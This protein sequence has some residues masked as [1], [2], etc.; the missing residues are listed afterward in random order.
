MVGMGYKQNI[1]AFRTTMSVIRIGGYAVDGEHVQVPGALEDWLKVQAFAA[2]EVLGL[3]DRAGHD[4]RASAGEGCVIEVTQQDSFTAAEELVRSS[5]GYEGE[6]P[7]LVLNFANPV[8][9][10]GGVTRGARAQEEDL[11][12]R[13]TLYLSLN[14][15]AAEP[16]YRENSAAHPGLFTH[17]ALVS[18]HVWVLRS[19]DMA[20]MREPVEVAVITMAAPYVPYTVAVTSAELR[21]TVAT[22]IEGMLRIAE[23]LGYDRLVLGAWGC[24]VFGNDPEQVASCFREALSRC[25][26]AFQQVRFAVPG[27]S[28]NH[29]V[30][31][32]V[33][34]DTDGSR[35][36]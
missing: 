27:P 1:R 18:P 32:R 2:D 13:S 20:F 29:E 22:R 5:G 15:V 9:P 33:L 11:C 23:S 34:S 24:G 30:F 3:V 25:G 17:N 16:Y 14:S 28:H 21:A 36:C 10:G 35:T 4:S 19:A 31:A 8:E 12:R 6:R 26:G 7:P